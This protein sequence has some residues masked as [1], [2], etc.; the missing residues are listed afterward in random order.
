MISLFQICPDLFHDAEYGLAV[1]LVTE[2]GVSAEVCTAIAESVAFSFQFYRLCF[3]CFE[4][5]VVRFT[6]V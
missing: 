6:A 5:H 4:V 1:L 2:K 3:M